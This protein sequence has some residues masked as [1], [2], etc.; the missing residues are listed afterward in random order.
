MSSAWGSCLLLLLFLLS[1]VARADRPARPSA[2]LSQAAE[3]ALAAHDLPAALA[4]L[5]RAYARAPSTDLL[6]HLG[7][8]AKEQGRLLA[9]AD[10]LRRYLEEVGPPAPPDRRALIEAL[11]AR[12][13]GLGNEVT[14]AGERGAL[15]FVDDRLS[16]ALPLALPLLLAPGPHRLRLERGPRKVETQISLPAGRT[17]EVRF[18]LSPA[19]AF[20]RLT[21]VVLLALTCPAD[22]PGLQQRVQQAVAQGL[23]REHAILARPPT[24]RRRPSCPEAILCYEQSA[25]A[26]DAQLALELR[27]SPALRVAATLHDVATGTPAASASDD[28]AGCDE[29][30]LLQRLP[31]L[32]SR[33][34]LDATTRG[35]GAL[36]VTGTA[37]TGAAVHVDGRVLG[38]IPFAREALAGRHQIH[39]AARGFYPVD[40]EVTVAEGQTARLALRL[41]QMP[42]RPLRT[43]AWVVGAVGLAA[44]VTGAVLW[45]L[46]GRF[47]RTCADRDPS[48]CTEV[49][50]G[51][52][53]GLP[54]LVP[55]VVALGAAGVLLGLDA[56]RARPASETRLAGLA[57]HF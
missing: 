10:L 30:A 6:Y 44:V 9:A 23:A 8:V 56:R 25:R 53:S 49:W 42:P 1:A 5:E 33:L 55:G 43:A 57:V 40:E 29:Q 28:C 34:L 14:V 27:V 21:H 54:V 36:Q 20:L 17:A 37:A 12:P 52:G 50:D 15:L 45:G 32:V 19:V 13:R 48:I 7:L 47:S 18:T 3:R 35:R 11:L 16:G 4:E 46:D 26:V 2:A 39:V 51:L 24:A 38:A 22:R 31:P 41:R